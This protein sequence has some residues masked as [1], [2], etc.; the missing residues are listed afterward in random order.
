MEM[1]TI[2]RNVYFSLKS[3]KLIYSSKM[4]DRFGN[5]GCLIA[6]SKFLSRTEFIDSNQMV[7]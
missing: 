4:K 7:L 1:N 2:D 3:T 6:G 5:T